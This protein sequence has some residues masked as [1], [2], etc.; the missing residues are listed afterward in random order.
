MSFLDPSTVVHHHQPCAER[1]ADIGFEVSGRIM[2]QLALRLV[3]RQKVV[4]WCCAVIAHDQAIALG[5]AG[6]PDL[7]MAANLGDEPA[8]LVLSPGGPVGAFDLSRLAGRVLLPQENF[9]AAGPG[10]RMRPYS[11]V[12][13]LASAL[14]PDGMMLMLA[15]GDGWVFSGGQGEVSEVALAAGETLTVRGSAIA[16]LSATLVVDAVVSQGPAGAGARAMA[17]LRGPG[18]VWLQSCGEQAD[19]NAVQ[20]AYMRLSQNRPAGLLGQ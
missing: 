1:V 8:R 10:V 3:P 18:R 20:A 11:C 13:A 16:A 9:L 17:A 6:H 4:T 14:R 5:D 15:E 2:Q 19:A 12:K 7:V